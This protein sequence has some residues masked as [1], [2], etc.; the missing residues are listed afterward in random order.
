MRRLTPLAL[1]LLLGLGVAAVSRPRAAAAAAPAK[2]S[3]AQGFLPDSF[4]VLVASSFD[5]DYE[6]FIELFID[7]DF[8]TGKAFRGTL[9]FEDSSIPVRGTISRSG[10]VVVTGNSAG[11]RFQ[12]TLLL[13]ASGQSMA[14]TYRFSQPQADTGTF[15]ASTLLYV[16]DGGA[17]KS[18]P[19]PK[20]LPFPRK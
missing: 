2:G 5:P 3:S 18:A 7:P 12:A 19:R 6:G 17:A 9:E 14:G 15:T 16:D 10:K 20:R 13:S 11:V 1:A 4:L 8:N